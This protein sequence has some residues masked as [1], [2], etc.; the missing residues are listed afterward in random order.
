MFNIPTYSLRKNCATY[1]LVPLF[2]DALG[3]NVKSLFLIS[4]K[5]IICPSGG[6]SGLMLKFVPCDKYIRSCS[7]VSVGCLKVLLIYAGTYLSDSSILTF[8]LNA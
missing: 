1:V 6:T 7:E 5:S 8:S 2:F 4:A 3:F